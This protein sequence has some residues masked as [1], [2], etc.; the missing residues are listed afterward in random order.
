MVDVD[1]EAAVGF[2]VAHGDA[3]DRARLAW[4]TSETEPTEEILDKVESGQAV[5]GG[6]PALWDSR[7]ASIDATCF[8]L[9]ELDDLGA[10]DRPLA[11]QAL[12]WL[13]SRQQED[14]L[15]EED[16]ALAGIAPSWARPGDADAQLYLTVNAGSGTG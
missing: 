10:L 9:G 2:V 12:A 13:A 7:V 4:L 16:A 3:V 5:K 1:I 11:R 15:W 14:G 6:W 8:R